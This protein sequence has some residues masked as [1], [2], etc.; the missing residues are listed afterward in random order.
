MRL[1]SIIEQHTLNKHFNTIKFKGRKSIIW[2]ALI[3]ILVYACTT[4]KNAFLNRNY[5]YGTVKFN[6]YFNGNE[7][8]KLA[9]K[10]IEN[11]HKDDYDELLDVFRYGNETDNKTEYPNLDRAIKKGA[12]MIDRHSMKFKVKTQEVE[13][14]QMI[15]DCY[16]LIGKARFLKYDLES[17]KETFLY[18]QNTYEKGKER[19][20]ASLW[21]LMTY[22]YQ[23]NFVDAETLI[24]AIKENKE[25]PDKLKDEL[26]LLEAISL[27]RSEQYE[28]AIPA[29]ENALKSIKKRKLKRRIQFIL[30]Q[31]Y[32]QKG[33]TKKAAELY[34]IVA[35][36]ATSYDLQF[37]A[38]I[39][40]A[41][42]YE[43]NAREII[44]LLEK[45]LKDSKNKEYFDQIYFALAKVYERQGNEEM[46]I[47]CYKL[48]AKTSV[49]NKKQK[50]KAFLALGNYYFDQP[51]YLEASNYYDS[52]LLIIDKSFPDYEAIAIKKESL[53]DL[54]KHLKIV[55]EQDSLLKIASMS[56]VEREVFIEKKIEEAKL[57]A[58][59]EEAR[60]ELERE[61][62][63]A[64]AA[65]QGTVGAAWVFDNQT[66][67][68]AGLAEFQGIWGDRPLEDDWRRSDKTSL[69]FGEIAQEEEEEAE[70]IPEDQTEEYYLKNLP[71]G[72]DQQEV[73][74]QK[75]LNSYYQ[76][77]VLYRDN[78][79][80]LPSSIYYFE[81]LNER[82]PRNSKEAVT[83]YQLYRNFDKTGN[84]V[85]KEDVKQKV[86]KNYPGSEY[87]QLLLNPNMLAEQE[88]KDA[89]HEKVYEEIF[90]IYKQENY[91]EVIAK[92]DAYRNNID[93]GDTK[94]YF[95]LLYAFS[96]GNLEGKDTLT[97]Y[98]K[99]VYSNNL[100]TEIANEVD[101]LLG[102]LRR[103]SDLEKMALKDSLSKEKEFVMSEGKPHYF[104]IVFSNETNKTEE[105]INNISDFNKEF[106]SNLTLNV[107]SV[108][109]TD[110]EDAI[111][112]KT[113]K[114]SKEFG[115]YYSTIKE[116]F[117]ANKSELGDLHFV[118]ST[119]NYKKLFKFKE[120]IRYLDFHK[121]SYSPRG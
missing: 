55:Q 52:T 69:N 66:A 84:A 47:K 16:L 23:E 73:S 25:F 102:E 92:I 40:L 89:A 45:M 113:F 115:N 19:Y 74:K 29:F 94:G 3:S 49:K 4:E 93:G 72:T 22:I 58:E 36:K 68:T 8:Y 99:Q 63:L 50:G 81:K 53:K 21:L 39:N 121:R 116:K 17:A 65:I 108:A 34:E 51:D 62:A 18:V 79:D 46:T 95:E 10:N 42:T 106:Y 100:G 117:L 28:K 41:T 2:I 75:I 59:A 11:T 91:S 83:W 7:A 112:V 57:R 54:V 109:W 13:F 111:V 30:G 104:M 60:K 110:K 44:T 70:K 97:Y 12:K 33:D 14:N 61:K 27:K 1:C 96:K 9:K 87:A 5:H 103:M 71:L 101:V 77:G 90:G 114:T 32:Q 88:Q 80:D 82:F 107:K 26:A 64:E 56:D 120:L 20:K 67:L 24:K 43:G 98:L 15:D 37:N 119:V 31:L 118:I 85:K 6:G 105:V 35:K 48:S 76:L 38:K 86:I 78:F